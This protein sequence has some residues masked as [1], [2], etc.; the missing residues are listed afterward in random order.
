[1]DQSPQHE[2]TLSDDHIA[3][4]RRWHDEAYRESSARPDLTTDH[5]GR[6]FHIPAGIHPITRVS[7]LLGQ[8]VLDEV[9]PTDR[10]L[11]MGTG[12]GVNAVLAA[13]TAREVLAVDINPAAI[14]AT[15]ANAARNGVT[16]TARHSDVFSTVDGRF[17]LIVFDPPFRWFAPRDTLEMASTDH[18]YRAMNSFFAH[19]GAH[20]T[21]TARLL[22]F[23]GTSG[24]LDHLHTRAAAAGLTTETLATAHH[25][26]DN[27]TADYFTY[28]MTRHPAIE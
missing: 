9:R 19:V 25:T 1:M 13:A 20:M 16:L 6:T 11:D 28:R 12:C 14:T 21:D 7:H 5:L 4:V 27:W 26:R 17:D 23:F 2:P 10:V 22:I 15:E 18:H 3:R 24:D 8:A